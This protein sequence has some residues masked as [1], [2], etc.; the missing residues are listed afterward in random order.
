[1]IGQPKTHSWTRLADSTD[2]GDNVIYINGSPNW[3]IGDNIVIS[4][5][6]YEPSEAEI[7]TI[8]NYDSTTGAITV[9][10]PLQYAHKVHQ[11]LSDNEIEKWINSSN[12]DGDYWWGHRYYYSLP[13]AVNQYYCV[14]NHYVIHFSSIA[15]LYRR[16]MLK[17][18]INCSF[19]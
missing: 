2:V 19:C 9:N 17:Q 6:S 16:I 4:S 11:L 1:M 12:S 13:T 5:S 18:R 14:V 7:R 3:S 8:V 10:E 15:C